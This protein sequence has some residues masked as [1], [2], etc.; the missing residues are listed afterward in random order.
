MNILVLGG[1]GLIGRKL[2]QRLR[3]RGH[4]V[5]PASP[6]TGV[7]AVTGKGLAEAVLGTECIV[8]VTN[9]PSFADE[10]VMA[11][12]SASAGNLTKAAAAA[13]VR[14]C[15][16]LSVVG[17]DELPDSGYMRAKVVQEGLIR[18]GGTPYTIVRA[19]QFFEFL[20]AVADASTSDGQVRVP[21]IQMQP[22][23]ADD[24]VSHLVDVVA[25]AP[26]NGIEELAG[27]EVF[28]MPQML[29]RL[30][31]ASGDT[32]RVL[33]DDDA[34]YFGAR[35]QRHSLLPRGAA[36]LG[37]TSLDEWLRTNS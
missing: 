6:S 37:K 25:R 29:E 16:T 3:D 28:P 23:A 9:A 1:T 22:I 34:G 7:D 36:S 15:V 21:P 24:L 26:A 8:D 19:T 17:A 14:H 18:S 30:L 33:V 13:G 10:A 32:R 31:A 27:P 5:T 35:V 4:S 20:T 11:F 2:T 12:F